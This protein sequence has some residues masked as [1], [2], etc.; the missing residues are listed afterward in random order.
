MVWDQDLHNG[1]YLS[2]RWR[3]RM[4]LIVPQFTLQAQMRLTSFNHLSI[5]IGI[6]PNIYD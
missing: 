4:S 5:H 1:S 2:L 3:Y 6:V